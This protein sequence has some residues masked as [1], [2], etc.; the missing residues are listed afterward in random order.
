MFKQY[1]LRQGATTGNMGV[2]FAHS[3]L[4]TALTRLQQTK[5]RFLFT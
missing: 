3:V 1:G 4:A 5:S 2:V